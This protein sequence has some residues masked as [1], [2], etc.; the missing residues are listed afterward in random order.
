MAAR[1]AYLSKLRQDAASIFHA[2]LKAVNAEAA[3]LSACR[4]EDEHLHTPA[5][6]IDLSAI[7]R[8]YVIGAGKASADMA[9]A[10]ERLLGERVTAGAMTVKYGHSRELKRIRLTEAGHP[11]PDQ[12]GLDGSRRILEI[13]DTAA[14]DDLVICLIS[15]GGSALMPLPQPPLTLSDKQQTIQALMD[16]G[17]GINEINA[18]RKH[19]SA[20]KGGR[21]AGRIFPA[22]ALTL[23]V[24]DVI[25]DSLDVIASGPTVPDTSRF[26]DCLQIIKTY[27]IR[28]RLPEAVFDHLSAGAAGA[29][30]ETPK[31]DA[32]AFKN[33]RNAIV[34]S[35]R[36][37]LARAKEAAVALG[38]NSLILSALI[39]GETKDAARVH[40]AIAMEIRQT[41]N[42]ASPPACL[43]SGGETTVTIHGRGK[44]GRNQEF[45]LAAALDIAGEPGIVILSGG[46]DGT[47]GPTDAAGAVVDANTVQNAL[48]AGLSP[49]AHLQANNAYPFFEQTGELLMTGPTGTNV[50]DLRIVL[51][52]SK[53]EEI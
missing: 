28:N 13:A 37:A 9:A 16:C 24:S 47:D 53:T 50:M 34:A 33:T 1:K 32:E 12:N 25:G 38:Y 23:I 31:A 5:G 27:Q 40:A 2:G 4:V 29:L 42:P 26:S 41:G 20:I 43:L 44:G 45:A 8:I 39:Q 17:A 21:L 30:E 15:G 35:S 3:V 36:T 22:A 11:I 46:T 18:I 19:L 7:A 51:V 49:L 6:A 52:D 10:I 48:D 14:A